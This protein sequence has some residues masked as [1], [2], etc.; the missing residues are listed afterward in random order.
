LDTTDHAAAVTE[1]NLFC[2]DLAGLTGAEILEHSVALKTQYSD[3]VSAGANIDAGITLSCELTDGGK[4]PLRVPAPITSVVNPDGTV[5]ITNVLVSDF[6]DN[7]IS[8][9]FL[10]SDGETV[11]ALLSGKL[12]R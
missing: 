10:L 11:S 4:A 6:V 2:A 3:A 8:G 1:T 9:N 7:W 12:D 5:D